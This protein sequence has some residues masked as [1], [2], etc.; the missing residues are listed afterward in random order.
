MTTNGLPAI[1][2]G[3]FLK[4]ALDELGLRDNTLVIFTCDNGPW[5]NAA[6]RLGHAPA[7]RPLSP[8]N[9]VSTIYTKLGIDPGKTF[10]TPAGR[11]SFLVSDP[12]PIRELTG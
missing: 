1:H 3:E 5:S 11:P 9:F 12:T 2:P 7:D 8:E 6:D 10:I 4:E